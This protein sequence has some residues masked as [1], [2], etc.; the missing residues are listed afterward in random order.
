MRCRECSPSATTAGP[1]PATGRSKGGGGAPRASRATC[2]QSACRTRAVA[3]AQLRRSQHCRQ[4]SARIRLDFGTS[5]QGNQRRHHRQFVCRAISPLNGAPMTTTPAIA[6][7]SGSSLRIR[8]IRR[9]K[10]A[11]RGS[12]V[13]STHSPGPG[14]G[15]P[16]RSRRQARTPPRGNSGRDN[17]VE[18]SHESFPPV[19]HSRTGDG[20]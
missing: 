1:W 8:T 20:P 18:G 7:Q 15:S 9:L 16:P 10:G 19:I 6:S 17:V 5:L 13:F 11:F 3:G 2:R 12:P 4:P 14:G